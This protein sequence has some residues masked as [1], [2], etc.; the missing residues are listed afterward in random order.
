M[1][2]PAH[3]GEQTGNAALDRVQNNVRDLVSYVKALAI[4][5]LGLEFAWGLGAKRITLSDADYAIDPADTIH[6]WFRFDGTLT[7]GRTITWPLQSTDATT[8]IR[9]V[10][11][12]TVGGFALTIKT[13]HGTTTVATGTTNALVLGSTGPATLV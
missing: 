12:V 3:R 5:V 13:P 1:A 9:F 10:S 8:Q 4:R 11:N 6:A 7:A 2:T